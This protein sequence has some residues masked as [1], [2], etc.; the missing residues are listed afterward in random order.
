ML[1]IYLARHGQSEDNLNHILGGLRDSPLTALG[2]TQ[3]TSLAKKISDSGIHFDALYASP[4]QRARKTAE[5]VGNALGMIPVEMQNLRERDFGVMSGLPDSVVEEMC[6]P[7]IYKPANESFYYFLSPKGAETFPDLLDRAKLI[8]EE[9]QSKH[10]EG[11]ILL[12]SHSDLGKMIYAQYY[13]LTSEEQW[14]DVLGSCHFGN[15][16]LLLLSPD[17]TAEETHVFH[18]D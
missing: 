18:V 12:V 8:L 7:D 9:L 11:N 15:S 3:A 14:K 5:I 2:I 10:S 6:K 16:D 13:G 1:K 17:T 4:L